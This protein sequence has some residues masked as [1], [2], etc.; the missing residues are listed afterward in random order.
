MYHVTLQRLR[1]FTDHVEFERMVLDILSYLAYPGIDPQSP[2]VADGGKDGLY[3]YADKTCAWFAFSVRKD[4]KVKYKQDL[5]KA[6]VSGKAIK[7]FVFCTNRDIPALERDAIK[8]EVAANHG[9]DIEF[10]DG[11]RLRVALDTVCKD[12]RYRYLHI[13]DNSTIRRQ[14][15]YLL[16]DPQSEAEAARVTSIERLAMPNPA[17]RGVFALLKAADLSMVCETPSEIKALLELMDAYFALRAGCKRLEQV[18]IQFVHG[19]MPHNDFVA[20]WWAIVAYCL[21]RLFGKSHAEALFVSR[22]SGIDH[23][24]EDCVR[25][26][27]ALTKYGDDISKEVAR[28][29]PIVQEA[30]RE[31]AKRLDIVSKLDSLVEEPKY[32]I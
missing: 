30:A 18:T 1:D 17:P 11:E 10:F 23:K 7:K 19:H 32:D 14:L 21:Y 8:I 25:I 9:F 2:T 24:G 5:D 15:R 13:A 28:L 3:Y 26:H 16:L 31:C 27:D 4:W 20:S 29:I 12:V 22:Q 6:V